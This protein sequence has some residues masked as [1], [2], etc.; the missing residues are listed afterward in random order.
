MF[1]TSSPFGARLPCALCAQAALGFRGAWGFRSAWGL[2]KAPTEEGAAEA[3][4]APLCASR[5]YG[6]G[7]D[8]RPIPA[9]A[10]PTLRPQ[11]PQRRGQP[12]RGKTR[13]RSLRITRRLPMYWNAD[14]I[15]P[16]RSSR[17]GDSG[18]IAPRP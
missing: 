1:R 14:G 4:A 7:Y 8:P 6:A 12:R 3:T 17:G 10:V 5:E 2:K 15:Q 13:G 18:W 16:I 11:N 9:V